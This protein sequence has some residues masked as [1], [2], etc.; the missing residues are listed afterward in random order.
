VIASDQSALYKYNS[1]G[2]AVNATPSGLPTANQMCFD[3]TYL[4]ALGGGGVLRINTAA[5]TFNAYPLNGAGGTILF[6][7]SHVWTGGANLTEIDTSGNVLQTVNVPAQG[8]VF[9]GTY[10]WAANGTTVNKVRVSDGTIIATATTSYP[11]GGLSF[12]GVYVWASLGN[13][14]Y[15]QKM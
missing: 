3:G 7:G 2:V 14:G 13:S 6:D 4:W 5:N 12:D 8:I 9:D 15:V 1:S 10:V 11:V